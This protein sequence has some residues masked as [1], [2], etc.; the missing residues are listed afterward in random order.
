MEVDGA[1]LMEL[2]SKDSHLK[3]YLPIIQDKEFY[4]VIYDSKDVV[5]SLPPIINGDHSKITLA[6]K[7]VFIECTATDQHK[8][9]QA[10]DVVVTMFSEYC[11]NK[12]EV[13]AVEVTYAQSGLKKVYPKLFEREE[14]VNVG[15]MK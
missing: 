12:F 6:T 14:T 4:P 13:E 15:S 9:E 8:A 1:E 3:P 11:E 10:L 5:C 7:N 2:Y